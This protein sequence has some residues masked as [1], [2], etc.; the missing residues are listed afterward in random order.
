MFTF[1]MCF[2]IV[3]LNSTIDLKIPT[4]CIKCKFNNFKLWGTIM[5]DNMNIE[6]RCM[7]CG[8]INV[9]YEEKGDM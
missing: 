3:M 8:K 5:N 2:R 1:L 6:W 4:L 9:T 7:R